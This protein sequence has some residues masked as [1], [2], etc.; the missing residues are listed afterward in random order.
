M[1]HLVKEDEGY[2]QVGLVGRNLEAVNFL[3]TFLCQVL[4]Q[5]LWLQVSFLFFIQNLETVLVF[6][7]V[8]NSF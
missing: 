2:G 7:F 1:A 6:F 3:F 5:L 8:F 4:G